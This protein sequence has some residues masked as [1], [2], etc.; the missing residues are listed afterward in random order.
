VFPEV[1]ESLPA[2]VAEESP[3]RPPISRARAV[4][5]VIL[6]SGY[7]T[8]LLS[9]AALAFFG[10]VPV[11]DGMLSPDFVFAISAIDTF[12]LLLLVF[13]LL[14]LSGERARDI[15][16]GRR[17]P[18]GEVSVGLVA[19]PA[20]IMVVVVVQLGLRAIAPFLHNVPVS[21]F[22]AF[23]DSPWMLVAFLGL[24]VIAGGVREELQR[25]F[26]LHRFEQRLGGG[27]IG[28]VV[29]SLS[30][31]LGHTV[32]GWDAAIATALL[33]ACWGTLYLARRSIVATVTSH[34]LFNLAQVLMGYAA[35]V[36]GAA[37]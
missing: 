9:G 15:F 23:L 3:P 4:F 11:R 31:G 26:L 13:S 10:I 2:I 1:S 24:V 19:V 27:V 35:F 25:A 5:E 36:K 34:A 29:T 7:P 28:L 16:L 37:V 20:L 21:P 22:L 17:P 12:L 18:L 33:G 8:Q 30:F 14:R 6:C 32:Q